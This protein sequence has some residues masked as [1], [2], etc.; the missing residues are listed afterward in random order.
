LLPNTTPAEAMQVLEKYRA[1]VESSAL[2]YID[3]E[4]KVNV[5]IGLATSVVD[6]IECKELFERADE[7]LYESKRGGRNQIRH[8]AGGAK[9]QYEA[10]DLLEKLNAAYEGKS[11]ESH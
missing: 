3:K 5:S 9:L 10:D 2:K 1:K 7:S 8:W 4:L 6:A 11:I